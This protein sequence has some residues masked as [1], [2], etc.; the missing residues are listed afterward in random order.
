[1]T[2]RRVVYTGNLRA[3][4]GN[5]LQSMRGEIGYARRTGTNYEFRPECARILTE[6]RDEKKIARKKA[7]GKNLTDAEKIVYK[8]LAD[9]TWYRV[10]EFDL[11]FIDFV[12]PDE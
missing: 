12:D 8:E 4:F 10:S 2:Q 3:Y 5:R 1:M 6:N 11:T 9:G 7:M